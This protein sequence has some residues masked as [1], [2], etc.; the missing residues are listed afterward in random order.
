MWLMKGE[1]GTITPDGIIGTEDLDRLSAPAREAA[2]DFTVT[3]Y[4]SWLPSER[5]WS[6]RWSGGREELARVH[7][8]VR[9]TIRT[10]SRD[11]SIF[12][13]ARA[14]QAINSRLAEEFGKAQRSDWA[15]SPGWIARVELELPDEVLALIRK[16]LGE[17]YSIRAKANVARLLMGK[18]SELRAGWDK[19]LD[20]AAESRNAQ[21]AVQLAEDPRNLAQVLEEV[22]TDRRKGAENLLGL[23][24]KIVE[25]QQSADILDLVVKS[26]TVLR[27]TLKMMGL[28]VPEIQEGTLIEPLEGEI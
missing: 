2:Y 7:E 17:E 9:K 26:E 19:F 6:T 14:E 8:I 21:H 25:A 16:T 10:T 1:L 13:P 12:D 22:L 15:I 3:V 28:P 23:I 20:D 11:F 18:I 4:C 5:R 27:E 24:N